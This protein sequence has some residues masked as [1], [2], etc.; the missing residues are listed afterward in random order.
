M[1]WQDLVMSVKMIK[2]RNWTID[3]EGDLYER[4]LPRRSTSHISPL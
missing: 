3:V 1:I 2:H 4:E